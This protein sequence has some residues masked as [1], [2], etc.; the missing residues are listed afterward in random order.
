MHSFDISRL[1]VYNNQKEYNDMREFS[2]F[3]V[4]FHGNANITF[5]TTTNN[6]IN[7]NNTIM[8]YN[9]YVF[10]EKS[11]SILADKAVPQ[12]RNNYD[13]NCGSDGK[14]AHIP[15]PNDM[16]KSHHLFI[17]W[18]TF[19][20]PTMRGLWKIIYNTWISKN[21]EKVTSEYFK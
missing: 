18:V 1:R 10:H 16:D 20:A 19:R 3:V 17:H 12:G 13:S 4:Y 7:F 5:P 11:N 21:D 2:Q 14:L 15:C 9:K 8:V 6:L